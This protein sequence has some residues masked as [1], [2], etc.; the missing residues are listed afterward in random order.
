MRVMPGWR[1]LTYRSRAALAAYTL[2]GAGTGISGCKALLSMRACRKAEAAGRLWSRFNGQRGWLGPA[3]DGSV[4]PDGWVGTGWPGRLRA[5]ARGR[6]GL[7]G[8]SIV[9]ADPVTG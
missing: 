4:G 8:A 6:P 9:Q 3:P 1:S 7:D 5:A 2:S